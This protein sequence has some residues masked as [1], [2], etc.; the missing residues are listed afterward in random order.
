MTKK[1]E[2]VRFCGKRQQLNFFL[3]SLFRI[4]RKP[5]N[6]LQQFPVVSSFIGSLVPSS[7]M[8]GCFSWELFKDSVSNKR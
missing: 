3:K 2:A 1:E 4:E 6:R 7:I 8:K 5:S